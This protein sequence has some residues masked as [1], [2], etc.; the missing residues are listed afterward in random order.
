MGV[1]APPGSILPMDIRH[2]HRGDGM[3]MDMHDPPG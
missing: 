1:T 2:I 3:A